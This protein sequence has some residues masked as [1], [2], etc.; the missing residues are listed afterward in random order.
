MGATRAKRRFTKD[1]LITYGIKILDTLNAASLS[2]G[3]IPER[4][5]SQVAIQTALGITNDELCEIV[6][7]V[8]APIVDD[9]TGTALIIYLDEGDVVLGGAL[10]ELPPARISD[11]LAGTLLDDQVSEGIFSPEKAGELKA[12]IA[13]GIDSFTSQ[14]GVMDTE[15]CGRYYEKLSIAIEDGTRCTMLYH[16]EGEWPPHE[17]TIDP[18]DLYRQDGKSY[19]VAWDVDKD[20]QR[21]YLLHRISNLC[22]TDVPASE[23]HD[24]ED[25]SMRE[26][27]L[28]NG[29]EIL[30]SVPDATYLEKLG[31]AG[32]R[33]YEDAGVH[34]DEDTDGQADLPKG[35]VLATVGCTSEPWLFNQ[36][37]AAGGDIIIVSPD[38]VRE[39]FLEYAQ[40]LLDEADN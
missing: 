12:S 35:R 17:R 21:T 8:L 30:F 39:R 10:G 37:L 22:F 9:F 4:R 40:A 2:D 33:P 34:V 14:T 38:D 13:K 18:H 23:D 16:A 3:V 11:E 7:D 24:F 19:L 15:Q 1:D 27:L 29:R 6:D 26:S 28:A 5:M 20:Q 32:A 25:V 31:W 36:V